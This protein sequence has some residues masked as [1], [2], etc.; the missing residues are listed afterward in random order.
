MRYNILFLAF[1]LV[2]C[3]Q[4]STQKNNMVKFEGGLVG[5]RINKNNS[6]G[7]ETSLSIRFYIAN[8]KKISPVI[9]QYM[10]YKLGSNIKLLVGNDTLSP[11]LS[12]SV[13]LLTD[14]EKEIINSYNISVEN[15]DMDKNKIIIKDS[16][17][18]L[19]KITIPVN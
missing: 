15:F 7:H 10:D 16:I 14:A 6:S 11:I 2:A 12:Y 19:Y 9:K 4:Q 17:F 8:A 18:E 5:A 1:I 13:P 3:R